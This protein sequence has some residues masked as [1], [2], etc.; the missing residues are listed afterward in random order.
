MALVVSWVV[1]ALRD[2][3]VPQT[4]GI[5]VAEV[6]QVDL[7]L[8][9][10]DLAGLLQRT[11]LCVNPLALRVEEGEA[12]GLVAGTLADEGGEALQFRQ[13][14][15]G[16]AEPGADAQPVDVDRAVA[17]AASGRAFD[18]ADQEL[19]VLVEAQGVDAHPDRTRDL[20]DGEGPLDA[21]GH[22]SPALLDLERTLAPSVHAMTVDEQHP[23][24]S[25]FN[26]ASTARDVMSGI[27][28]T[29][30]TAVVTGG[31][32]GLGL[33]S[34]KALTAAGARVIVPARR[35]NVARAALGDDISRVTIVDGVDLCDLGSV[36]RAVDAI[37][38]MVDGIDLLIAAAGV[39]AT[40]QRPVGPGWDRQLA[41]NHLGHFVLTNRLYPLLA[42]RGARV[43]VYSS[44]GH[45]ASD[46][47]W[48][49]PHFLN[50]YDK[51]A[52]YGQS[53]TANVLFAVHLD[54]LGQRDGVRAFA[55]HPGKIITGLQ[56][57]L[58]V[59]EQVAFG[60]IDASGRVVGDGFK[61]P[62]QGAATGLWAAT[63]P[64]LA[65]R[66]GLYLED[67]DV[68]DVA[69]PGSTDEGGVKPYAID[70]DSAARLWRLSSAITAT[71]VL[72]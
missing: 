46:I 65:G 56:R 32:S 6:L 1:R 30:R 27:D 57:D 21:A 72:R 59:E 45:H 2:G 60:W 17:P 34:T 19:F 24:G 14:H 10:D 37:M 70:T 29:D 63:S 33:E 23:L 51:W 49:D 44:A 5:A 25:G 15:P 53:K 9:C 4:D 38:S 8:P 20:A 69:R 66:G 40:P 35:G 62:S 36:A 55:L 22:P 64:S 47:R 16:L 58:S 52:A 28:L 11:D 18:S 41:T 13:R 31:Y 71:N 26:A 42:A 12:F 43:V 67:C 68:A 7:G 61:T 48:D 50:G 3:R 54:R 39:M